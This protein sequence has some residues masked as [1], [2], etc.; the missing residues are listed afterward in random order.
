METNTLEINKREIRLPSGKV[1]KKKKL[2]DGPVIK[3]SKFEIVAD[4]LIAI[5]LIGV[6]FVAVVP[7]W[8][9]FMS[10]LSDGQQLI[11]HDGLVTWFVNTV[12]RPNWAGY[13]KTLKYA[14]YAVV[15]SYMITI[16]YVLGNVFVGLI[17]NIISAYVIYRNTKL[18]K[19]IIMF[20]IVTMLFKGGVIPT[21]MVIRQIGFVNTPWALIIPNC[22][23]A[24]FVMLQYNAFRQVP[25]S[26][27]EAAE[28]D[29]ASHFDVMFRVLLPQSVGLTVVVMI[30]TAI[31]A[32]NAW[33][34]ASIYVTTAQNLWPLQLWIR[35]IVADNAN[36]INVQTPDWDKYLVSYAVVVIATAP[37]LLL[38]P[39][40][41]KQIQ[42]GAL[43][44]AEKG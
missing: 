10:S 4:I 26:T 13:A 30:N 11:A 25:R 29:G 15:K 17:I 14:D 40:V 19:F 1:I 6:V 8:H 9:T 16:S 20:I 39:F 42:K 32:W 24:M 3:S 18:S 23:N 31:I 2:E 27:V 43:M 44:G 35:Q 28:I 37:I 36:I 34:Q 5:V 21:Y 7:M 33:F 22:T 41:Q 38:M 12:N